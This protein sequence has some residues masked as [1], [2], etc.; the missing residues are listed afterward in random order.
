MLP[1]TAW[2][3][4]AGG[5]N[6]GADCHA[7]LVSVKASLSLEKFHI[8]I[9][10]SLQADCTTKFLAQQ[11]NLLTGCICHAVQ[12]LTFNATVYLCAQC[13]SMPWLSFMFT[14]THVTSSKQVA[15]L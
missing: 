15:V 3:H 9:F 14:T 10:S 8:S 7:E 13:C 2:G 11:F 5:S 1:I 12:S 6:R 4:C